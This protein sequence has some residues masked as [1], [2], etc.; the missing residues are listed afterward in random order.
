M[1]AI[2]CGFVLFGSGVTELGAEPAEPRTMSGQPCAIGDEECARSAGAGAVASVTKVIS[3]HAAGAVVCRLRMTV[4]PG[5]E[6]PAGSVQVYEWGETVATTNCNASIIPTVDSS[7]TISHACIGGTHAVS[8]SSSG[9]GFGPVR[10]FAEQRFP[11]FNYIEWCA[12]GTQIT[13]I[14]RSVAMASNGDRGD[15]CVRYEAIYPGD[16]VEAPC[17]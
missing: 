6:K 3:F 17:S 15:L 7:V 9:S 4:S 12:H 16:L 1:V 14:H 10:S 2:L 8:N 13:W 5:Y 11:I